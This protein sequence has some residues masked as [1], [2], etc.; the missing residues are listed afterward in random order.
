M[1]YVSGN[2]SAALLLAAVLPTLA[3]GQDVS[4]AAIASNAERLACYDRAS[5]LAIT[6]PATVDDVKAPAERGLKDRL[7]TFNSGENDRLRSHGSALTDQWELDAPSQRGVFVLR[8]YKPIYLLPL[9]YTNNVNQSP[10]SAAIGHGGAE[11]GNLDAVEARVQFSLK[12]KA[13]E[14]LFGD[15]GDLWLGYTQSSRWQ[16]YNSDLSRPF[17]ETDYEPEAMLAFHTNY[18]FLG[19]KG[20]LASI[21]VNH[22]S[23]GRALPL[24]RSWNRVIA[25]AGFE[26]DDWMVLVRPWWRIPES[27][28]SDDNPGIE[29]Y[30]GRGE[31]IVAR[32]WQGQVF[33]LQ[34]RHSLRGGENSR[35]SAQLAWSFPIAGDL[36]GYVQVFSGY[37]ESLID[38]NHRQTVIGV[39]VS[40]FD[41]Y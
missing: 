20:S 15:N 5:L 38:Y 7:A 11:Q 30:I 40:V 1:P 13:L 18:E 22:Q 21:G 41:W 2:L 27:E 36:K 10:S 9:S 8:P 39:G 25:Q 14:N 4:C 3:I 6:A 32:Q 16:A 12:T 34:A 28:S 19:F 35:G 37:G 23:N 26:K 33:S 17:R 29:N 31:L 24:S